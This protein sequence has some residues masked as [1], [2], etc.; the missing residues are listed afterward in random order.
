VSLGGG[1]QGSEA[2]EAGGNRRHKILV[3]AVDSVEEGAT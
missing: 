3:A 2:F 1:V